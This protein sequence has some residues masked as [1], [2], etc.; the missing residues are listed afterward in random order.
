M[1][2]S[3]V[4]RPNGD[5]YAQHQQLWAYFD[6]TTERHFQYRELTHTALMISRY[7]PAHPSQEIS[8]RIHAGQTFQFNLLCNP[9]K[10]VNRKRRAIL[11]YDDQRAWL[12]RQLGDCAE[13]RYAKSENL[14]PLSI[15]KPS[16]EKML[17]AQALITGMVY[18]KDRALFIDKVMSGIGSRGCWGLGL[19]VLPEVMIWNA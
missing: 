6:M 10:T 5:V 15:K 4:P 14:K 7:R 8:D 16:G 19:M 13:I 17:V 12:Q 9:V 2:L 11:D 3:I 18:V 1:F